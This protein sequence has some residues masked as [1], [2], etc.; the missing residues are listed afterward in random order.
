M[1]LGTL[2]AACHGAAFPGMII[3]FGEMI[4]LFVGSGKFQN[5]ING[6][7]G[8][9]LLPKLNTTESALLKEPAILM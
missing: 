2:C 3:V 5:V 8:C 4:D 1:L 6:I 7:A 9:G